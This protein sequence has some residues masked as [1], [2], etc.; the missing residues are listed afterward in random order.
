MPPTEC[1]WN[2]CWRANTKK[3]EKR[4]YNPLFG[5]FTGK[6]GHNANALHPVPEYDTIM[7]SLWMMMKPTSLVSL[8]LIAAVDGKTRTNKS[9]PQCT[10]SCHNSGICVVGN[11]SIVELDSALEVPMFHTTNVDGQYC[12]CQPG[13]TGVYCDTYYES[14]GTNG[15]RCLNGGE[16]IKGLVDDYGNPQFMCDCSNATDSKGNPTVGKYCEQP[17]VQ[18][19]D[20]LAETF[21][22]NGAECNPN[23]P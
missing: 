11:A 21:C 12:L 16:C 23:Y 2:P 1:L 10:L 3:R 15:A 22:V 13:W 4:A 14:C 8:L 20:K 9:P 19:C 17:F 5:C 18:F 7:S 6:K